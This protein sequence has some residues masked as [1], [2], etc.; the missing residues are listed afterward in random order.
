M[1]H[2]ASVYRLNV[3]F[4]KYER[5]S[6]KK[7]ET[8]FKIFLIWPIFEK[9]KILFSTFRQFFWPLQNVTQQI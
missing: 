1:G 2:S 4:A 3:F 9:I 6:I 7:L 5:Q 8:S